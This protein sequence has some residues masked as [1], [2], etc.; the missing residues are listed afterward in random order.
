[1]PILCRTAEPAVDHSLRRLG[2]HL[3][4]FRIIRV[5]VPGD[6]ASATVNDVAISDSGNDSF[7]LKRRA[8]GRW[9]VDDA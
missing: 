8:D 2:R 4:R 1:M 7:Q 9:L 3:G 6:A 5:S